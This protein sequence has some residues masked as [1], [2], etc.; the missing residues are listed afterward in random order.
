MIGKM[1]QTSLPKRENPAI[2]KRLAP[3]MPEKFIRTARRM[4]IDSSVTRPAL[5]NAAPMP[6]TLI[7]SVISPAWVRMIFQMPETTPAGVS[8]SSP[9][10]ISA[11]AKAVIAQ[12]R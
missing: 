2:K 8:H 5:T 7:E 11:S 1:F 6:P 12:K 4:P 3:L 9:K 10:P